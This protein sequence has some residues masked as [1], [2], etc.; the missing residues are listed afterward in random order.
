METAR[1]RGV[2]LSSFASR[3]ESF[4]SR[5]GRIVKGGMAHLSTLRLS[6]K[7]ALKF[8][9]PAVLLSAPKMLRSFWL[10]LFFSF[11]TSAVAQERSVQLLLPSRLLEPTSTFELRFA[12]EMVPADQIGKGATVSP[13]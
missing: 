5:R 2:E 6:S 13:L 11:I 4:A 7:I 8:R 12:T 10:A 9:R 1:P 3:A